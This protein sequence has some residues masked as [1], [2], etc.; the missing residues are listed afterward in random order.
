MYRPQSD[1]RRVTRNRPCPVCGKPDWCLVAPDGTAAICPRT[2]TGSVQRCGDAG[3]LHRLDGREWTPRSEERPAPSTPRS[4]RDFEP[5]VRFLQK[6]ADQPLRELGCELGVSSEALRLLGTGW[7]PAGRWWGIPERDGKGNIIGILR[8]YRD[9]TKTRLSGSRSGLSYAADWIEGCGPILLVE[10][11][12]DTAAAMTLGLSAVGR[13]SNRGGTTYLADLLRTQEDDRELIVLGDNDQKETGVW[14]GREGAIDVATELSQ[15]LSRPIDW[16]LTP[17]RAKDVRSWL[18]RFPNTPSTTLA[19][20]FLEGLD[21]QT[22]TPPPVLRVTGPRGPQIDL[23][24]YRDRMN[25]ARL[26][27]LDRPGIY[28]DRSPTGSGK[29]RVDRNVIVSMIEGGLA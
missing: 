26:K 20:P 27:S 6:L 18:N 21:R 23:G 28:L 11:P 12:S 25:A 22:I 2:E 1:W 19:A 8:R 17:D 13:P 10:G 14:P 4:Q 16:A 15:R 24:D 7:H 9:G 5:F 3:W 29:S